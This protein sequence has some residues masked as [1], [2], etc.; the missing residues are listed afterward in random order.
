[1]ESEDKKDFSGYSETESFV[2]FS[3][4]LKKIM[5]LTWLIGIC[6]GLCLL[7]TSFY[8]L[9]GWGLTLASG[10]NLTVKAQT[11]SGALLSVLLNVG[12]KDG[13]MPFEGW[14]A[15]HIWQQLTPKIYLVSL[16]TSYI[17]GGSQYDFLKWSDEVATNPREV[18]LQADTEL[19]A[20]YSGS[21]TP[22]SQTES[23]VIVTVT[24]QGTFTTIPSSPPFSIGS[25]LQINAV[26]SQ[27]WQYTK[28]KRN[29]QDWTA[30]NPGVF[31]NLGEFEIIEIVFT[32][33]S[34]PPPTPTYAITASA[35]IG[36]SISPLGTLIIDSGATQKY[37]ITANTGYQI[38]DV[39]VDG[40][41]KG[42][43]STYTFTNVQATHTISASFTTTN[44]T[45]PDIMAIIRALLGNSQLMKIMQILGYL[46]TGISALMFF[47][48]KEKKYYD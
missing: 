34:Q 19:T 20:I 21:G 32:Q 48:P 5:R 28:M 25:T 14:T 26:P 36:G 29:G 47:I 6:V 15:P 7:Y 12:S 35:G 44:P 40:S 31:S 8:G 38:S 18:N 39:S 30:S 43:I 2:Y 16:P 11:Q 33:T 42:V 37:S 10:F 23:I 4:K 22:P 9:H 41:S 13:S 46:I 1:L 27:G 3:Y 17:I 45:V 24:G